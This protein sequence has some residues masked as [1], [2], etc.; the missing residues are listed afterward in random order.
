MKVLELTTPLRRSTQ[1]STSFLSPVVGNGAPIAP[2]AESASTSAEPTAATKVLVDLFELDIAQMDKYV[3]S[4]KQQGKL[5]TLLYL[6]STHIDDQ[7]K[8]CLDSMELALKMSARHNLWI[9]VESCLKPAF[10]DSFS[11]SLEKFGHDSS[12]TITGIRDDS[13]NSFCF[14]SVSQ[15][16]HQLTLLFLTW[17]LF[18]SPI[19][20]TT[21]AIMSETYMLAQYLRQCL[22]FTHELYSIHFNTP[23]SDV[24]QLA[25]FYIHPAPA[26]VKLLQ[27]ECEN[28]LAMLQK[29]N[30]LLA[31]LMNLSLPFNFASIRSISSLSDCINDDVLTNVFVFHPFEKPL[32]LMDQMI[33]PNANMIAIV[34]DF[35]SMLKLKLNFIYEMAANMRPVF[36][37]GLLHHRFGSANAPFEIFSLNTVADSL[38][39]LSAFRCVPQILLPPSLDKTSPTEIAKFNPLLNSFNEKLANALRSSN[40]LFSISTTL[41]GVRCIVMK[42]PS[43]GSDSELETLAGLCHHM[44]AATDL[45]DEVANAMDTA[46]QRGIQEAEKRLQESRSVY[47][48]K[49]YSTRAILY[50]AV[51]SLPILGSVVSYWTG[52]GRKDS[53]AINLVTPKSHNR[54]LTV[55]ETLPPDTEL[56]IGTITCEEKGDA[57]NSES[58]SSV[59][60]ERREGSISEAPSI[61]RRLSSSQKPLIPVAVSSSVC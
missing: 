19:R 18:V 48:S 24:P 40:P 38:E 44:A 55:Q 27:L 14:K 58:I 54:S 42:P 51:V 1:A 35:V 45:P 26:F 29:F 49:N 52:P 53:K 56:V 28:S 25:T 41:A 9:H 33:T 5:P 17:M 50:H 60:S 59:I 11:F 15:I 36:E 37:S 22:A 34:D 6:D 12:I 46:V 43:E 3:E 39:Y 13:I 31:S 4:D 2:V 8:L 61:D 20:V 23:S 16:K 57:A 47:I 30:K 7:G 32:E 10:V 21:G